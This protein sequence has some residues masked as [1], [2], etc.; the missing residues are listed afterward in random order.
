MEQQDNNPIDEQPITEQPTDNQPAADEPTNDQHPQPEAC[1][2]LSRHMLKKQYRLIIGELPKLLP[3]AYLLMIAIGMIFNYYKY[4]GFG[5]N[6]FQYASVFDF[7]IA[8]FED[9]IILLFT[10]ISLLLSCLVYLIDQW[11]EKKYPRAYKLLSF[12]TSTKKHYGLIRFYLFATV[13]LIYIWI[14]AIE[15]GEY[16]RNKVLK[17]Q[18]IHVVYYNNETAAGKQIGKT[19]DVLFLL[20]AGGVTKAIPLSTS[21]KEIRYN[22]IADY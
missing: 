1:T 8:P 2:T 12:N 9:Y 21:V 10:L 6:I 7:L 15:Y 22:T 19:S 3:I 4:S 13:I 14:M 11:T 16:A 20:D 18:D 17:Q 5:I